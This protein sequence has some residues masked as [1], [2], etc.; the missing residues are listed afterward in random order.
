M[1]T[2]TPVPL[3]A[4][5]PANKMCKCP[6]LYH[7]H[8]P[9]NSEDNLFAERFDPSVNQ[10]ET[11]EAGHSHCA[12]PACDPHQGSGAASDRVAIVQA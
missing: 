2:P 9:E 8:K 5:P 12:Q 10:V 3:V 7:Q 4:E 1:L 11:L 6:D